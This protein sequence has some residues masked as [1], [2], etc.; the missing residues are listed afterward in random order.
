[1]AGPVVGQ[2]DSC[3]SGGV[4]EHDA[5]HGV[6]LALLP[7]RGREDVVHAVDARRISVDEGSNAEVGRL[8]EVA[9]LIDDLVARGKLARRI[10]EVVDAGEEDE[11]SVAVGLECRE[12][13]A[14]AFCVHGDPLVTRGD[15]FLDDQVF[16][17]HGSGMIPWALIRSCR[18]IS[19]FSKSSGRG[20]QPGMYTSTGTILSTPWRSA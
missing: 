4:G 8:L 16:R 6:R 10:D 14:Y 1:M 11:Q 19:A 2:E 15:P 7:V 20:G 17:D 13:L 5:E 9:Q 18:I 3:Q 12:R